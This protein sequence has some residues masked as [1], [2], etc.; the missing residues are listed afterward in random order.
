MLC[1]GLAKD[2]LKMNLRVKVESSNKAS[3]IPFKKKRNTEIKELKPDLGW[4]P[5]L[6]KNICKTLKLYVNHF[7]NWQI[8]LL[9]KQ[10]S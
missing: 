6:I 2:K 10:N 9:Q 1:Y 5:K 4:D 3:H 8:D 7:V